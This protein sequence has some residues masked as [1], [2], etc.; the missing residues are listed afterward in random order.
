[1][2]TIVLVH[3]IRPWNAASQAQ[4]LQLEN[5]PNSPMHGAFMEIAMPKH[6]CVCM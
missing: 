5:K 2:C 3:G 4:S 6:L 1:M